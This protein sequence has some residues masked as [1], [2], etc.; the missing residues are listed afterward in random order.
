[1][2]V[3]AVAA[4]SVE[5]GVAGTA[6]AHQ[7]VRRVRTALVHRTDVMCQRSLGVFLLFQAQLA[8]GLA[9]KLE[10]PDLRPST[11]MVPELVFRVALVLI[12]IAVCLPLVFITVAPV[13]QI[14]TA[15]IRA[16]LHGFVGHDHLA[17]SLDDAAP[18]GSL[19]PLLCNTI[20]GGLVT[21]EGNKHR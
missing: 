19:L 16:G 1:M 15:G 4:L 3:P 11:V 6:Q 13:R 8:Q 12:V 7:V 14:R 10:L 17:P 2:V 20:P 9:L 18:G 5:P 21:A